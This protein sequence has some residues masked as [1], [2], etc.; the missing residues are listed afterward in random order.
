MAFVH[1]VRGEQRLVLYADLVQEAWLDLQHR[2]SHGRE[3]GTLEELQDRTV[4][5][6]SHP[7]S[8]ENGPTQR[9]QQLQQPR[10]PDRGTRSRVWKAVDL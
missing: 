3:L 5:H 4:S 10:I 9:S 1:G 7:V 6:H 2:V 8:G